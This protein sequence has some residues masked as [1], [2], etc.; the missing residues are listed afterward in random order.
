MPGT[1]HGSTRSTVPRHGRYLVPRYPLASRR[2]VGEC[3]SHSPLRVPPVRVQEEVEPRRPEA[4]GRCDRRYLRKGEGP[5]PGQ[6]LHME[7]DGT[8]LT[9]RRSLHGGYE[10]DF[11][12]RVYLTKP[13]RWR[14]VAWIVQCTNQRAASVDRLAP[15]FY[16]IKPLQNV[17]DFVS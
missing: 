12:S 11:S 6:R 14:A 17:I 2:A 15:G 8:V 16:R 10:L 9:G 3:E 4:E 1:L 5:P 7:P 13:D